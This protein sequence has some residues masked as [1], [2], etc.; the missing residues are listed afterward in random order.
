M[1]FEVWH[2]WFIA[3]MTLFILEI[4]IPSF[5]MFNFGIGALLATVAASLNL[6]QEMQI[7]I[8]CIGTLISFFTIRPIALR[9][10]YRKSDRTT[11]NTDALI[12]RRGNVTETIDNNNNTGRV[13]IDGD[14]WRARTLNDEPIEKGTLVE[15]AQLESITVFVQKV[16]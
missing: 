9:Y 16:N 5:V 6:S 14:E 2:Y 13:A 10:A 3:S 1:E 7:I 12:G 8:F 15:I 4:F 11:T